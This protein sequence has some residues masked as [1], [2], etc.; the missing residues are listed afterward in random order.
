MSEP[1]PIRDLTDD[2]VFGHY[3]GAEEG[4]KNRALYEAEIHRRQFLLSRQAVET[5]KAAARASKR[6]SIAALVT[7]LVALAS[8]LARW[9]FHLP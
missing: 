2:E 7:A 4:S 8:L 6:A 1:K 5:A 3:Q 9:L